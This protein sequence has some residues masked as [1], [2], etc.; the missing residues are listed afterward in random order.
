VAEIA[1]AVAIA[2]ESFDW[3]EKRENPDRVDT[4]K[5]FLD[6]ETKS[7]VG[8]WLLRGGGYV[9]LNFLGGMIRT[10]VS[11]PSMKS[12][13]YDHPLEG[14]VRPRNGHIEEACAALAGWEVTQ[15]PS[16]IPDAAA[17]APAPQQ[18]SLPEDMNVKRLVSDA[19]S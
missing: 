6:V 18:L 11:I 2:I 16:E 12:G 5:K 4:G 9:R 15:R 19:S 7:H 8:T 13:G 17:T 1:E 10:I 3:V 14:Y